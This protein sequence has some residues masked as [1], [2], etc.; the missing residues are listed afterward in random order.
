M[1]RS[2]QPAVPST[3]WRDDALPF[4]EARTVSDGREICYAKHS[5]DTFS[6]G[7]IVGGTSTYLNG[8][9]KERIGPGALVIIDPAQV[10]ACNP[11]GPEPWAYRMV[12]VDVPWLARLQH[13]LGGNPNR[14]FHGFPL[15]LTYRRDLF[16]PF[17]RFYRT[18]L[19]PGAA[20]L[21]KETAA[22]AFFTRLHGALGAVD[23]AGARGPRQVDN[24]KL[25][26]AADYIAAHCRRALTLDEI[27]AAADLSPSYL[28]RAFN[29]RY[30]M[31]PHA[32]LIDRRVQYGRA[33]LRR[34][35][36]IAEVALDA[37]F[38]DQAHF[39]RAFR[40]IAA[41]TPGQYRGAVPR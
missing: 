21:C 14:D 7:A 25:A 3:F 30:G 38:A 16:V 4:I 34:G 8:A 11:Y 41:A 19:S 9:M 37:G 24:A 1:S 15:K 12:Y 36:P 26:R 13:M 5:H 31:T 35:R 27:C 28:I 23:V 32:Y 6:L 17:G 33:E 22:V 29:A 2:V 40:R 20:A 39:Q 18:L 10:H